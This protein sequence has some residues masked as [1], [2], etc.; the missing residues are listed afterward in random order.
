MAASIQRYSDPRL[1]GSSSASSFFQSWYRFRS[2][3][4]PIPTDCNR[5]REMARRF[6]KALLAGSD[7]LN[8]APSALWGRALQIAHYHSLGR[9]REHPAP[10]EYATLHLPQLKPVHELPKQLFLG[11][12]QS[13]LEHILSF[14]FDVKKTRKTALLGDGVYLTEKKEVASLY[15]KKQLAVSL[16]V[17]PTEI[18][19]LDATSLATF[20]WKHKKQ[21]VEGD[22]YSHLPTL[23][24]QNGYKGLVY[25]HYDWKRG[26]KLQKAFVFFD[27]T[28]LTIEKVYREKEEEKLPFPA[29]GREQPSLVQKE[30]TATFPFTVMN[31]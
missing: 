23:F 11:T 7:M 20:Q 3:F 6:A 9:K 22:G 8:Q 29:A 12:S 26:V 31:C 24:L 13:K 17:K 15:G 30:E 14:G 18:A 10:I 19:Y 16:D 21:L 1:R 2:A 28:C 27:P 4:S 25:D 5:T